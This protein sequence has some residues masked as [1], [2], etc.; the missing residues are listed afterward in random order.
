MFLDIS[1][2][3]LFFLTHYRFGCFYNKLRQD[4][5]LHRSSA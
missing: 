3:V 4:D 1:L 2:R 5:V